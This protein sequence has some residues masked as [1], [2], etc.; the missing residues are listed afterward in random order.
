MR[1]RAAG[2]T[3]QI[4]LKYMSMWGARKGVREKVCNRD[5]STS[6]KHNV[7][8]HTHTYVIPSNLWFETKDSGAMSKRL[9]GPG[10]QCL[11]QEVPQKWRSL[12][13]LPWPSGSEQFQE[14]EGLPCQQGTHKVTSAP[15][16]AWKCN[17]PPRSGLWQTDQ[18]NKQSALLNYY[19]QTNQ[20]SNRRAWGFIGKLHFQ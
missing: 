15:M 12:Q 4:I 19:Q 6:K 17:F 14:S 8:G 20:I 9:Y 5:A 18:P 2:V 1:L 3:W 10:E 11:C 16:G 7:H 13:V